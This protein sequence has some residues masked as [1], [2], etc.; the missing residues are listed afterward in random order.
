MR[1]GYQ[2]EGL[3]SE[4]KVTCVDFATLN[5]HLKVIYLRFI[6]ST[7][8]YVVKQ[9]KTQNGSIFP[10]IYPYIYDVPFF[11]EENCYLVK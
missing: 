9:K 11:K 8:F 1:T 7:N 4:L 5:S 3:H 6:K 2:E 10:A